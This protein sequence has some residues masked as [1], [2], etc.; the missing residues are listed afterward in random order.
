MKNQMTINL[1]ASTSEDI[2]K[3]I[4]TYHKMEPNH[5]YSSLLLLMSILL[6]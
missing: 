4:H 1:M 6:L 5:Y 2:S 3:T